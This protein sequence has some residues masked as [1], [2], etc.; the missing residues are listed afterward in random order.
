MMYG[1]SVICQFVRM[2]WYSMIEKRGN[3]FWE[4]REV[5]AGQ[6]QTFLETMNGYDRGFTPFIVCNRV[7]F[8]ENCM[9]RYMNR[10]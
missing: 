5:S 4:R 9:Q 7:F 3:S 2:S 10:T 1:M 6:R 8:L